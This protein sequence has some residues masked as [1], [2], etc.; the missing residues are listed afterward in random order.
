MS[1]WADPFHTSA[2]RA[3]E[4][5][6]KIELGQVSS[7]QTTHFISSNDIEEIAASSSLA[8]TTSLKTCP[9]PDVIKNRVPQR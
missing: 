9:T 5:G 2:A 8:K 4:N 1:N 3:Q 7:Y 6:R